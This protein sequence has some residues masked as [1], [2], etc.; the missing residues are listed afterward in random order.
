M[1]GFVSCSSSALYRRAH[2]R[3]ASTFHGQEGL[4]TGVLPNSGFSPADLT[5][6]YSADTLKNAN[7]NS[8]PLTGS[9]DIWAIENVFFYVPKFKLLGA[10]LRLRWR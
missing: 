4:N 3:R 2:S 5:L 9:Y 6:N 8:V 10:N 1:I 7:G